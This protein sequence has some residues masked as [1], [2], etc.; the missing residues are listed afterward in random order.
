MLRFIRGVKK[1]VEGKRGSSATGDFLPADSGP[2]AERKGVVETDPRRQRC[3]ID[4]K[5][6]RGRSLS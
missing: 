5:R 1:D 3:R 2:G 6:D 4:A